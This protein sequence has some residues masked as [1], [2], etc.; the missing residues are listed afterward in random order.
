MK[1]ILKKWNKYVTDLQDNRYKKEI[2]NNYADKKR[3]Q[4]LLSRYF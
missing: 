4:L 1:K 3:K 2:L